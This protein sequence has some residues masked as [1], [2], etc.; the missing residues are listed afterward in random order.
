MKAIQATLVGGLGN[1][2]FITAA[3]VAVAERLSLPLELDRTAFRDD[4][5]GRSFALGLFPQLMRKAQV[6]ERTSLLPAPLARRLD[7]LRSDVFVEA[8][9]AYDHRLAAV[10]RPMRLNGYFQSHRYFSAI[11]VASLFELEQPNSRLTAIE[12]AV[13]PRWIAMH[14]RRGD[15]LNTSTSA[16]H[17]LCSSSYFLRGRDLVSR[18]LEGPLPLVIFTDQ[19][20]AV[21]QELLNAASLVLGPDPEVHEATDLWA[22]AS[23]QGLVISNSSFSWWAAFLGERDARPVVAPRPWFRAHDLAASDLLLPHWNTL[24]A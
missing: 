5:A 14:V 6:V 2:M 24:G 9:F 20:D 22:M 18:E 13:G 10:Q 15:Y 19:P 11:D 8:G 23:A 21:D 1:Q 4:P 17:G 12:A 7:Q 16:F 3:A